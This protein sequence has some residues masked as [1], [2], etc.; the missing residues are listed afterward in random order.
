LDRRRFV[1]GVASVA[2]AGLAGCAVDDETSAS[3]GGTLRLGM[4]GGAIS[5]SLDPRNFMDWVPINIG[6]QI[7]NGLVEIDDHGNAVP[8]LLESWE[9][10]PGAAQ[11]TFNV[12]RD[13]V[14][15]NGKTLD[16]DD[17][18]YSLNLHRGDT[19]SAS[20]GVLE[21]IASLRKLDDHRLQIALTAG[22]AE[23]PATLSDYRLLVAPAG[24][25]DWAHPV[26]TGGY[27]LESFVP[28]VRCLTRKTGHY[29][30]PNAG[31]VEAIEIIVINDPMARINALISGQVDIISRIDGRT[32]ELMKRN[33]QFRV[34]RSQ[35]GQYAV[36]AMNCG[37]TPFRDNEVRLALKAAIDRP[38]LIKTILNGYGQVGDDQPIPPGNRFY[39]RSAPPPVYDPDKARFHLKKARREG[40]RVTLQVSEAAFSGAVDAA[41]LYQASAARAG[42]ALEVRREPA[43]GYW[44]NVWQKA[45][46]CASYS[47]GR[48][49]VDAVLSKA[50][51]ST[52]STNDTDWRRPDFDRLA[53]QARA[54]LDEQKRRALYAE[55]QRMIRE[56]CGAVIPMFVDHVSAGTQRVKGWE[57]S[58]SLDLMGQRIGEKVWLQD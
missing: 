4:S 44:S 51:K 10:Q 7:M 36:L 39:D 54:E 40:L 14:F 48:N 24:F 49:T 5:D 58:V 1:A 55:C 52:S 27:R 20:R 22:D 38:A 37:S 53:N 47:D 28:G 35:T 34:V 9:A 17:V 46:F 19:R 31:L 25:T 8:E 56:D 30:K 11:W 6:Y 13:V 23:L 12:R 18:I 29:W 42:I 26:G 43:D 21:N 57:P 32:A 3:G 15:H 41:V 45:P 16:V 33:K 50:Y 2:A